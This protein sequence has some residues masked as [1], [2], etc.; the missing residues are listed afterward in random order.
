MTIDP[1]SQILGELSAGGLYTDFSYRGCICPTASEGRSGK[2]PSKRA[3]GVPK[4]KMN[5]LCLEG[6][7]RSS[8]SEVPD[9]YKKASWSRRMAGG[10]GG[11]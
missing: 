3:N 5:R 9:S 1:F 4:V 6:G 2:R 7:K 11:G 8:R 10:G